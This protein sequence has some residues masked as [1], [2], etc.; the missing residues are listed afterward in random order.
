MV[1][2]NGSKGIGTGFSTDIMSYNPLD[3]IAY[4]RE[5][6]MMSSSSSTSSVCFLPYYEGFKGTIEKISD[7]KFL[8]K[9]RYEKV[10]P[11]KIRVT[12]LP[13]G[14]WTESFKEHLENLIDPGVDKTGKK[15]T[16]TVR[17][18]DDMSKDTTVDFTITLHKGKMEELEAILFDHNCNG[19]DKVFKL[20]TTNS[21][22][23]MHLFNAEDKLKKYASV[24]EIIDDYFVTRLQMYQSRKDFMIKS[25][26]KD[27]VL[28]SNR[29]KYIQENLEGTIDLRKR[30]RE[31]V[32]DL[33]EKKGYDVMDD[34]VDF[35]YLV[36][37]PMDSVTSENVEKIFREHGLKQQEL[38]T[39]KATTA[40]QMWVMELNNLAAAYSGYKEERQR[41]MSGVEEV[42]KKKSVSSVSASSTK[43]KMK[44]MLVDEDK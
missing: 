31:E 38:E 29:A 8:I 34:D 10:G 22:S 43:K 42:K 40:N 9:G 14:Y 28:L 26:E 11:E 16:P 19:I 44:T 12:E 20:C 4:L 13:V 6:L 39:V 3:I 23:N 41:L 2:V 15:I 5:K 36:K 35:K 24:E 18:Y 30:K 37:M 33:L 27:L 32:T 21:S 17:D 25:L 1:L 7:G